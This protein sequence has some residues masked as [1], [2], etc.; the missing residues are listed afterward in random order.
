MAGEENW[1]EFE[2]YLLDLSTG[3]IERLTDNSFFDG[4]PDWCTPA[5]GGTL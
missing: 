1:S 5:P 3:E 4:H 2:L